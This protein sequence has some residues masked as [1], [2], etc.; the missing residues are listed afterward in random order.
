MAFEATPFTDT[1]TWVADKDIVESVLDSTSEV[2]LQTFSNALAAILGGATGI[3]AIYKE[4]DLL[5][6]GGLDFNDAYAIQNLKKREVA[7]VT[8]VAF[9]S[10]YGAT[11]DGSTSDRAA[12][13]SALTDLALG[14]DL[15]LD[16]PG[17]SWLIDAEIDFDG[18]TF[19]G[20]IPSNVRIIGLGTNVVIKYDQSG[21]G[22]CFDLLNAEGIEFQN[23]YFQG[24]TSN[25]SGYYIDN[26]GDH[27]AIRNCR[28]NG[29]NT[30]SGAWATGSTASDWDNI[31]VIDCYIN[32]TFEGNICD[33]S[34]TRFMR[35]ENLNIEITSGTPLSA[36]RINAPSAGNGN[37]E[38]VIDG[39]Y[40]KMAAGTA[41]NATVLI[42]ANHVEH[43]K[44]TN[45][46]IEQG[47]AGGDAIEIAGDNVIISHGHINVVDDTNDTD[48]IYLN[49]CK[50]VI[51]DCIDILGADGRDGATTD[52]DGIGVK[53]GTSTDGTQLI[54]LKIRGFNKATTA[55]GVGPNTATPVALQCSGNMIY[56]NG[57]DFALTG[58]DYNY[59]HASNTADAAGDSNYEV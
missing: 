26:M 22:N 49:S 44:I 50:D 20:G 6:K 27:C 54:A 45:F 59:G 14:G 19:P 17:T 25:G 21:G 8:R 2:S 9:L 4:Q 48:G 30:M 33:I 28:F 53:F 32:G 37:E 11:G 29:T 10:G 1:Q 3:P 58:T 16:T 35:V 18:S 31:K 40:I 42:V 24:G 34:N 12:F 5:L 36:V 51:L 15:Y 46:S 23:I 56:N 13:V 41:S 39:M 7:T 55:F 57:V 47:V 52:C 38:L 43:V